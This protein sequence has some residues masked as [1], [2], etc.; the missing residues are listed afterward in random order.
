ML[1]LELLAWW[2][3]RGWAS[4][5]RNISKM[6]ESVSRSFSIPLLLRTLFAPWRQIVTY[7]GA[8]LEAKFHALI[9]NMVSRTIGFFVRLVVLCSGLL[10]IGLTLLIGTAMALVWPVLPLLIPALF[11]KGVLG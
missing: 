10:T 6:T 9:D 7:P 2:Y 4:V 11:I 1:A 5:G 8:G 3:G